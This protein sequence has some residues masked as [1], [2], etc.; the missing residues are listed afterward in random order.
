MRRFGGLL[1]AVL[2]V[3]STGSCDASLAP[4]CGEVLPEGH[5]AAV[6]LGAGAIWQTATGAIRVMESFVAGHLDGLLRVMAGYLILRPMADVISRTDCYHV[7]G[8]Q[9]EV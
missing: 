5:M 4:R 3:A 6:G 9:K 2:A 1:L 7:S 8:A